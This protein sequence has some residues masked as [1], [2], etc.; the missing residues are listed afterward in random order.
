MKPYIAII[1]DSFREALASR[2]L[3]ILLLLITIIFLALSPIGWQRQLTSR[4]GGD[5]LMRVEDFARR[6]N[7]NDGPAETPEGRIHSQ[8]S[9]PLLSEIEA[10]TSGADGD[11]RR[12]SFRLR[13]KLA[14]ELDDQLA[15]A[16]FYDQQAWSGL[17]LNDEALELAG[18]GIENL[19]ENE[20][21][22]FNRLALEAAFPRHIRQRP[23]RSVLFTYFHW[24]VG[25]PLPLT[26]EQLKDCAS[27]F[28][29]EISIY[30]EPEK[31]AT[32]LSFQIMEE[33]I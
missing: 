12:R 28:K 10:F 20:L 3:W 6:L 33:F 8:L 11:D 26:D 31:P 17:E 22:R 16:D 30:L 1:K 18:Q 32:Q 25:V 24:D 19:P 23:S 2:V 7:T 4:V 21:R 5:D 13:Q 27:L 14:S 9:P 15:K 29:N